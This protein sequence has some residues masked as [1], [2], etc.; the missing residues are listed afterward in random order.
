MKNIL[1]GRV[2]SKGIGQGYALVSSQPISFLGGIDEETGIIKEK[3]RGLE[4]K[5]IANKVLIFPTG[6]G[7]TGGSIVLFGLA[8]KK[9]GPAAILNV[10]SDTITAVGAILGNVPLMDKF[11][12]NPV[13]VIRT[14][15]FIKV[16]AEKG[17]VEILRKEQKML[18][19]EATRSNT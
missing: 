3:I 13:E 1:R 2:V 6:K 4:G 16:D 17:V 15:D 10:V 12:R 9:K 19:G 11:D 5:T 18:R 8:E 14:G 7:S